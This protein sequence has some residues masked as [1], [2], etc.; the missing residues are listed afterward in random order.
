[1]SFN[2]IVKGAVPVIVGVIAAGFILNALRDTAF[3]SNAVAG[4]DS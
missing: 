3:F 4:F 1:M 2:T